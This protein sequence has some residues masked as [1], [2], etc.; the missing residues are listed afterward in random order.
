M[1]SN[2]SA[3]LKK[4]KKYK[5]NVKYRATK[6][7]CD[8]NGEALEW[9]IKALTTDEYEKIREAYTREVQVTGKPGIY[10]QKF[11]SSGF[12]SKLICASVVEPDLHSIE[13]LDSYGVMSPEDLIK[14]MVDNPGEYNE[15]AEFVQNFNGFDETLQDKVDEAKN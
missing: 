5:D 4:N 1:A 3:F 13:L 7:L 11:D 14:Q 12:L 10:R 8:E 2:L 15:F 6:S 9:E